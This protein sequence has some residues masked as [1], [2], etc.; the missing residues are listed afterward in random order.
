MYKKLRKQPNVHYLFGSDALSGIMEK[1]MSPQIVALR[2]LGGK[3]FTL[4]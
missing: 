2:I 3:A 4:D 1:A